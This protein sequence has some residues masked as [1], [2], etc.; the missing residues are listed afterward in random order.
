[1]SFCFLFVCTKTKD[2]PPS[3]YL[4]DTIYK[5]KFKWVNEKIKTRAPDELC[6]CGAYFLS[7]C[8]SFF[9][10]NRTS[11]TRE[12]SRH[13]LV[14]KSTRNR[15]I[16]CFISRTFSYFLL[17]SRPPA[18]LI[19]GRSWK[20]FHGF[21]DVVVIERHDFLPMPTQCISLVDHRRVFF[22]FFFA[23]DI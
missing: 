15:S 23:F 11:S 21:D 3:Y 16:F 4:T 5:Y 7:A 19:R 20:F 2:T 12:K 6:F 22:F 14:K 1:M 18:L 9:L 8:S 13:I 10:C 17:R